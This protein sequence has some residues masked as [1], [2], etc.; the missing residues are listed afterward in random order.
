MYAQPPS[1]SAIK[2]ALLGVAV[3]ALMTGCPPSG[4]APPFEPPDS[5]LP[6]VGRVDA[7]ADV[8]RA[9]CV[10][11]DGDNYVQAMDCGGELPGAAL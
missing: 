9:E 6:D 3:A 10:D 5:D 4:D 11:Q 7:D 2:R 1:A 8:S